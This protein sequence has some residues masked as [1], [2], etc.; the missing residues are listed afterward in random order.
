MVRT[1]KKYTLQEV[2]DKFFVVMS[3]KERFDYDSQRIQRNCKKIQSSL[4]EIKPLSL[5]ER[6]VPY[7]DLLNNARQQM[8]EMIGIPKQYL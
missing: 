3:P 5:I 1:M 6:C 7:L 2:K 8:S 4:L